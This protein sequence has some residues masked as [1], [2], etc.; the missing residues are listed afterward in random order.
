M[1]PMIRSEDENEINLL[2]IEALMDKGDGRSPEEDRLLELLAK[3]VADF[4]AANYNLGTHEPVDLLFEQVRT[5]GASAKTGV[6]K[7]STRHAESVRHEP[8]RRDT[9]AGS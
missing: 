3:L 6:E 1:L 4:E 2:H 8:K 7:V 5:P 9:I